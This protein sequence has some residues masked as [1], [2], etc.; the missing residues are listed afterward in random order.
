MVTEKV[1]AFEK[2]FPDIYGSFS[3]GREFWPKCGPF[4]TKVE[5]SCDQTV[6]FF[7]VFS[8]VLKRLC[9]LHPKN[10]FILVLAIFDFLKQLFCLFKNLF[11]WQFY[12]IFNALAQP[13]LLRC[14]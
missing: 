9:P 1:Q 8:T 7:Q 11:F 10:T 4:L 3:P 2:G 13:N 6:R 12:F 5:P 14:N